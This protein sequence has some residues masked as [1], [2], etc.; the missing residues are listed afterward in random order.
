MTTPGYYRA[1]ARLL[2]IWAR[3]CTDLEMAERLNA[4][5]EEYLVMAESLEE[6]GA[7][8]VSMNLADLNARNVR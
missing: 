1:Q 4:R 8:P 6:I 5:A 2:F 7:P 3:A